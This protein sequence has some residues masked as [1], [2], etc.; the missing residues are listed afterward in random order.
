M[1][2]YIYTNTYTQIYIY[3]IVIITR[4]PPNRTV[5]SGS[6]VTIG[7]NYHWDTP[8]PVTWIINGTSYNE[9]AIVKSPLYQLKNI[10]NPLHYS[11]AIF[12]IEHNTTFQCVIHSTSNTTK[13]SQIGIITV[14]SGMHLTSQLATVQSYNYDICKANCCV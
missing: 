1:Y 12:S 8:F 3:T 11:L 13:Y 9:S 6:G 14:I 4:S 10:E 7:C 2:V 5:C